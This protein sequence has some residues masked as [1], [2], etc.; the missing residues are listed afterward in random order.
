MA[1]LA[2]DAKGSRIED[3]AESERLLLNYWTGK[4]Y[5]SEG[6]EISE[7]VKELDRNSR[8]NASVQ[9]YDQAK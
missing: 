8:L 5:L 1:S 4:N 6:G 9:I 7:K 3:K 2:W